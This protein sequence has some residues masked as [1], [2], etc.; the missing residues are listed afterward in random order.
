MSFSPF[1]QVR[2]KR[3]LIVDDEPKICEYLERYFRGLGVAVRTAY[4]G[5]EAITILMDEQPAP[6]TVLL[7]VHLPDMGG[8]QVLRRIKELHPEMKVIMV[9]AE[10]DEIPR[11]EAKVYGASGY[12]TKPFDLSDATWAPVLFEGPRTSPPSLL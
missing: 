1:S 4:G 8:L 7:D 6:D 2:I 3:L 12:I 11:L 10:D 9:T 5:E